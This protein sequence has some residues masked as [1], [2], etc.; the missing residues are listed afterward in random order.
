[1]GA[2]SPFDGGGVGG[3]KHWNTYIYENWNAHA[4]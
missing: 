2:L 3:V 1:M 4:Q